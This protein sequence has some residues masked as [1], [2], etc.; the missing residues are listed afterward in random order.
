MS[1]NRYVTSIRNIAVFKCINLIPP[2]LVGS[3]FILRPASNCW[4]L[5]VYDASKQPVPLCQTLYVSVEVVFASVPFSCLHP[6]SSWRPRQRVSTVTLVRPITAPPSW[7]CWGWPI[8]WPSREASTTSSATPSPPWPGHASQRPS[9]PQVPGERD[10]KSKDAQ[11][12]EYNPRPR[13]SAR[14]VGACMFFFPYAVFFFFFFW[15]WPI[16]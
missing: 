16:K 1:L 11:M 12:H 8:P 15:D 2:P 7:A 13:C 5:C 10:R 9:C 6:E 3:G 4:T 14:C